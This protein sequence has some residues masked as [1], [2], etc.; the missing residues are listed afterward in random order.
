MN[1]TMLLT[2][3]YAAR[4]R[5]L[6]LDEE[7]CGMATL[8]LGEG[9]TA[10]NPLVCAEFHEGV[11]VIRPCE[12]VQLKLSGGAAPSSR[13]IAF[14]QGA[15]ALLGIV[16]R[17]SNDEASLYVRPASAGIRRWVRAA[18]KPGTE[19]IVGRDRS[20]NL[21][22]ASRFVSAHHL[23]ITARE[24]SIWVTDLGSS[25]G[26][27][28]DGRRLEPL[29]PHLL[30]PGS[31]VQVLDFSMMAGCGFVSINQP[32]DLHLPWDCGFAPLD[33]HEVELSADYVRCGD[34]GQTAFFPAPRLTT[35]IR[36]VEIEVDEPPAKRDPEAQSLL[37]QMGPT[38][39]M[40]LSSV[41]MASNAIS[42]LC[43]GKE[44]LE[45]AP[46]IVMAV[47]M[48]G[49]SVVWPVLSHFKMRR[50]AIRAEEVRVR[51]YAAYVDEVERH[52]CEQAAHQSR[53]LEETCVPVDAL[54]K[55]AHDRSPLLMSH[56]ST[57]ID[58]L[59]LRVGRGDLPMQADIRWPRRR[60]SVEEDRLWLRVE[61]LS[62]NMPRLQNV[63]LSCNLRVH[64]AL[65][66]LGRR[67]VGWEFLRGLVVQLCAN[68]S[69]QELKLTLIADERERDE[70]SFLLGMPHLYDEAEVSRQLAL[71]QAGVMRLDRRLLRAIEESASHANSSGHTVQRVIVCANTSLGE[72]SE[73][74]RQLLCSPD[75]GVPGFCIMHL[76][77][78]LQDLP[79]DCSYIIDLEGSL[80]EGGA[81]SPKAA[82][83]VRSDMSGTMQRFVPDVHVVREQA[84]AFAT[85]IA[86]L[87]F[88]GATAQKTP[89]EDVGFLELFEAGSVE[90]LDIGQRWA[91]AS[92]SRS[93][94]APL[95]K[96]CHGSLV[97][98]DL[99]ESAQGPHGLIAGTTGSGKSELIITMVLGLCVNYPPDEVSFVL[100]DY[101]GG[102]LAGAFC[103]ERHSLPHL[104]GVITNLDGSAIRRSLSSLK[105]ELR[106]RQEVLNKARDLAGEATMDIY[107]YL[108]LRK[109]EIVKE[110]LPHLIIVA[111]EFAELR[112]Q[113]PEFME[114]LMSAARIGRSLGVH[115]VLATQKPT[116]VVNDQIWSNARFKIC[117]KVADRADSREMLRRDDAAGFTNP[118][119]FCLLV[120]YN[121]SFEVGQS[122]YA[123]RRYVAK[124]HFVPRRD[125]AVELLDAEGQTLARMLMPEDVTEK[126]TSE[127][128]A[129]LEYMERL[130]QTSHKRA[131]RLWLEPL[132]SCV[133]LSDLEGRYGPTDVSSLICVVG[134]L[135]DPSRQRRMRLELDLRVLGNVALVGTPSSDAP[136]VVR[137]M[138][139]SLARVHSSAE[140]WLYGLQSTE[141]DLEPLSLLPHVGGFATVADEE[142]AGSL[143]RMLE[144]E[145]DVRKGR[146][147]EESAGTPSL[148][149]ALIGLET[150]LEEDSSLE[151]RLVA[152]TR[153]GP[154]QGIHYIVVMRSASALH[155]RLRSN[156][157][158]I[159]PLTLNDETDYLSLLGSL[160]GVEAPK[161][162]RR[163]II[164]WEK[165]VLEF[166]GATIGMADESEHEVVADL[167][168][169]M[170]EMC[171]EHAPAIPVLPEHVCWQDLVAT[172]EDACLPVG[173]DKHNVSPVSLD[174]S[175]QG[176]LLV[177]GNNLD[178]LLCYAR[179]VHEVLLRNGTNH[180]V[181][182]ACGL[183]GRE[184][185]ESVFA[186]ANDVER[187]LT[188]SDVRESLH[189]VMVIG[190]MRTI[191]ALGDQASL[192]LKELVSRGSTRGPALVVVTEAWRL[193]AIYEDWCRVLAQ[194][195]VALWVG[196]GFA[197]QT[198]IRYTPPLP[199]LPGRRQVMDG[200]MVEHGV[201]RAMR[202]LE[203]RMEVVQ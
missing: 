71:T 109:Q 160:E 152:L 153:E 19:V 72:R 186:S 84:R 91:G 47:G 101:K 64:R 57:D 156:F 42:G 73:A 173:Y 97:S 200:Y 49:G 149:C 193:S 83:F 70:W 161:G 184:G 37:S 108:E 196:D 163:G 74:I 68:Y 10:T 176:A 32:E 174:V 56:T 23:R 77:D 183:L 182:D 18:T 65:G 188:N 104:A 154:A 107:R 103:N 30:R 24:G 62:H 201:P 138:L 165:H 171:T 53:L 2:L 79:R 67:V 35:S 96:D 20:C 155:L 13:A 168:L 167:L 137:A 36:P 60:F 180:V 125:R 145:L 157:G 51:L 141:D 88:E 148:V 12:A 131:P 45:V 132:P 118:G 117:L 39:L 94:A 189:V 202:M 86:A 28:V 122:A 114:E 11:L 120:G 140:L 199:R 26:S 76:A 203:E 22:Y 16:I 4:V 126:G 175:L 34:Q 54:L 38:F 197:D 116:G 21:W 1:I 127:L 93:L 59:E 63:P 89:P 143:I 29:Q 192:V 3:R 144:R 121:E 61:Q 133:T 27:Y 7:L 191:E 50:A 31:I 147:L 6:S 139:L 142:R 55:R 169:G 102:G 135:D 105:S 136:S 15:S 80:V 40:A 75:G 185:D 162:A 90:H 25:N 130:A 113:E 177:A 8:G 115:L 151:D 166:Q 172:A 92:A 98:L 14:G 164:R 181:L 194:Q 5:T 134:E 44:L 198:T 66:I 170:C 85:D 48:L 124:E 190:V 178:A 187:L 179:G 110:P 78:Q 9:L 159:V 33:L 150:L 146:S 158:M 112:Q 17:G 95:G 43:G 106:R 111:D 123:G 129:V 128:N 46:S 58:F 100:I 81:S 82:M 99:V 69:P 52:L 195:P 119:R 87:R 41:F